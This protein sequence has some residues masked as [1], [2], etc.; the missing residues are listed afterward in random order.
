MGKISGSG[1]ERVGTGEKLL[2]G[3]CGMVWASKA[4]TAPHTMK[5]Y[6]TSLLRHALSALLGLGALLASKGLIN[7]DDVDAV[8]AASVSLV[9]ALVV[10][11]VAVVARLI[12]SK[13]PWLAPASSSGSDDPAGSS[14]N[15][16]D[17]RAASGGTSGLLVMA[18]LLALALA[19]LPSC[20]GFPVRVGIVVPEGELGYS[21]KG[22]LEIQVRAEK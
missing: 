6:L 21:S 8:S 22:G 20:A 11:V 2:G 4:T 12:F 7:P 1:L 15:G 19:A 9:D 16:V 17:Q 18:G 3:M 10:I 13:V 14:A 5:A